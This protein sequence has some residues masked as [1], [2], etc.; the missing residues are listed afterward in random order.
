[1]NLSD[2]PGQSSPL[3]AV[4]I[5]SKCINTFQALFVA[6]HASKKHSDMA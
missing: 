6:L 2:Q 1:M 5:P 3:T 4:K